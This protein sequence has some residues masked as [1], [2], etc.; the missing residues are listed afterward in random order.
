MAALRG[1]VEWEYAA[2]L[3]PVLGA[4]DLINPGVV[5]DPQATGACPFET[6]VILDEVETD[7]LP[8]RPRP[9]RGPEV[10]RRS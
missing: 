4:V 9:G 6:E 2:Q 3:R 10:V 8:I 1:D 7:R 5:I